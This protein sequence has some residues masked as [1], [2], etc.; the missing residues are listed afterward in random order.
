MNLDPIQDRI[1]KN[2]DLQN[3]EMIKI[4]SNIENTEYIPDEN[5]K[6]LL[7]DA[8]D[9]ECFICLSL[10][11]RKN[12]VY[13]IQEFIKKKNC[14]IQPYHIEEMLDKGYFNTLKILGLLDCKLHRGLES[15]IK[16]RDIEMVK[17]FI[18]KCSIQKYHI[19]IAK[20]YGSKEIIDLVN[21]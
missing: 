9:D 7:K 13:A 3:S 1:S 16:L 6:T 5:L 4:I 21:M 18:S 2:K 10:A 19:N 20:E 17:Y 15:S 11:C 14:F 8:T 12:I